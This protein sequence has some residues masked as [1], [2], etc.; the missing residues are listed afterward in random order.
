MGVPLGEPSVTM[1]VGSVFANAIVGASVAEPPM[2][3]TFVGDGVGFAVPS[4]SAVGDSVPLGSEVGARSSP[5]IVGDDV[6]DGVATPPMP[7][8]L[9]I[10]LRG[11]PL[12]VGFGDGELNTAGVGVDVPTN[13]GLDD[14]AVDADGT[15]VLL[16]TPVTA[17]V[18]L[19]DG[20]LDSDGALDGAAV[21]SATVG[22]WL[23]EDVVVAMVGLGEGAVVTD[24]AGLLLDVGE[25]AGVAVGAGAPGN[26]TMGRVTSA[27]G[28]AEGAGVC[29]FCS[30][31]P[32]VGATAE[33]V[34]S[35][36]SS[37]VAVGVLDGAGEAVG[38][39]D[40]PSV[41]GRTAVG[42]R[43]AVGSKVLVGADDGTA[44]IVGTNVLVGSRV[45]PAGVGAEVC[46]SPPSA[47][48]GLPPSWSPSSGSPP[49]G[50][51]PSGSPPSR[52]VG[53]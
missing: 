15:R 38:L 37:R 25:V 28:E 10:G 39:L 23:G 11:I 24:A 30:P 5:R 14:G 40:G 48:S 43:D 1:K 42:T 21:V 18:G 7:W 3:I 29:A 47:P 46:R 9:G 53:A 19:G 6:G 41:T 49:P 33:G 45:P 32:R 8:P 13:V 50:A 12:D 35:T 17:M 36:V 26:V 52:S 4:S 20:T 27:E 34:G 44:D 16:G 2:P 51:P 22:L 31:S